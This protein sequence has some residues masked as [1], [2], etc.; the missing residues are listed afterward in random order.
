MMY[1]VALLAGA[2]GAVEAAPVYS[3]T[4]LMRGP[5]SA[6]SIELSLS[7]PGNYSVTAVDLKW[8]NTSLQALS[9]GVFTATAPIETMVGAGTLEFFHAG[10][11]KVFLQ[12]YARPGAGKSAGLVGLQ[13]ESVTVV[14]LPASLW[15]LLSALGSTALWNWARRRAVAVAQ[16]LAPSAT[17]VPA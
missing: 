9:F 4:L 17:P 3:G 12:V 6:S 16:A 13:V 5:E 8:L 11:G 10:Q 14:A 15:L 2:G 7:A 1:L